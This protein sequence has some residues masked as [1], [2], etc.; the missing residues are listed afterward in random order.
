MSSRGAGHGDLS[1]PE[2]PP[3]PQQA[4][5]NNWMCRSC[6]SSNFRTR[7]TCWQC[8]TPS[9]KAPAAIP[10]DESVP[11]FEKEGFQ[12][13]M[14]DVP[15]APGQIKT[16]GK[17]TGEWTC[18]RCFAPNFKNRQDCHKCGSVKTTLSV[19]RKIMAQKPAKI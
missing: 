3:P 17:S 8:G 19:P 5:E 6:N 14:E 10:E 9:A 16:W 13:G 18:S 1:F 4:R 15:L 2:E 12:V 7:S 11:Q